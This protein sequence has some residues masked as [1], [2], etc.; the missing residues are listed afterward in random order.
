MYNYEWNYVIQ[1]RNS[2]N[3]VLL[4]SW[5]EY[6]ERS[7]LEPHQDFTIGEN[8]S[9][10]G[11]TSDYVQALMEPTS[12]GTSTTTTATTTVTQSSTVNSTTTT[13]VITTSTTTPACLDCVPTWAYAAMAVLL[14][15]G[16][17]VG[18]VVAKARRVDRT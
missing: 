15:A 5:N 18:Y 8:V 6:H 3:L 1:N 4:C 13:T 7:A 10:V 11:V 17:V 9:L 16:L 2:V 14:V 12:T